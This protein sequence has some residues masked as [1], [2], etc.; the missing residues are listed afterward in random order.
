MPAASPPRIRAPISTYSFGA[1]AA[2]QSAGTVR[3]MFMTSISFR[4]YR[5]PIAPK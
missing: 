1:Q 2:M 4:P 3:T 5:S